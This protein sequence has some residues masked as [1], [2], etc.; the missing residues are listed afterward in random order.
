MKVFMIQSQYLIFDVFC[1][2][3]VYAFYLPH[4]FMYLFDLYS[5]TLCF[6]RKILF[7]FKIWVMGDF[8]FVL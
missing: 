6:I 7:G 2:I 1:S 8:T 5:S 4:F 3:K